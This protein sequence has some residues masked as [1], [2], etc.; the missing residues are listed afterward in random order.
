[1]IIV[2]ALCHNLLVYERAKEIIEDMNILEGKCQLKVLLYGSFVNNVVIEV[3]IFFE[4]VNFCLIL[5]I[6]A[7]KSMGKVLIGG[8]GS[9]GPNWLLFVKICSGTVPFRHQ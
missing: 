7:D 1:M 5:D 3:C 8:G 9:V 6:T 2:Y 4:L